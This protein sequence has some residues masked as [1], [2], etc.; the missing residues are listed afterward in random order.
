M[1]KLL[2]AVMIVLALA[3]FAAADIYVKSKS[4][5]D[6]ISIMGQSQPAKDTIQEQWLGDDVFA[7]TSE[8][9]GS[10]V[11]LKKNVIYIINH[12]NKSYLEAALP[13]DFS[14]LLPAEMAKMAASM[15]KVTVTVSPNGQTKTVGQWKCN[16]Y[17]VTMTMMMMPMKMAVWATTDVPFDLDKFMSKAYGNMLAAQLRLDEAAVKEMMKVKGFWIST[18]MSAEMMGAKIHSTMEVIEIS[19]KTP[20]A[21]VY[22]VPAG[23]KKQDKLSAQ[24]LQ[25]R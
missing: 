20:P 2:S 19:K 10:V 24:D 8:D 14:S 5:T 25:K 15:M 6:P 23:Y 22:T 1:K 18:D 21:G 12:K 3:T 16:G 7:M 11:D 17:D 13:L 9:T 4:H